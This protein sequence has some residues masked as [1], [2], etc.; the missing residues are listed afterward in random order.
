[1]RTSLKPE[2]LLLA[3][4]CPYIAPDDLRFEGLVPSQGR[5][6]VRIRFRRQRGITLEIFCRQ[7][8]SRF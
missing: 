1:M 7:K 2:H 5:E 6:T 4:P 8:T 3:R